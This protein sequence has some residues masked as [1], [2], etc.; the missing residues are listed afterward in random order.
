MSEKQDLAK[1]RFGKGFNCAQAVMS[2]F[3]ENYGLD[4]KCSLKIACGLGGG[5]RSGEVCGA[6][7]GAVLV[8]GLRYGQCE[9][10]DKEAKAN[11]YAKTEE[12]L[13]RFKADNGSIICRD[14]LGVDISTED[15][16]RIAQERALFRTKCDALVTSA[17]PILEDFG[18]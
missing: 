4:E 12:F 6:A 1:A 10:D 17:V 3:S 8:V 2:V 15:G 7:S 11:C 13:T 18:Y 9:I 5:L 14:L 16:R